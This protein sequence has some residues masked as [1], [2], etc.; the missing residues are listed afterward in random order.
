MHKIFNGVVTY[1][2]RL[3]FLIVPSDDEFFQ[4]LEVSVEELDVLQP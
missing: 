1:I 4:L 2:F 3:E